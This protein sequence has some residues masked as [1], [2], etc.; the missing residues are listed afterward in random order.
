MIP[1]LV[2]LA[3]TDVVVITTFGAVNGDKVGSTTTLGFQSCKQC[4]GTCASSVTKGQIILV[5][6]AGIIELIP[7]PEVKSLLLNEDWVPVN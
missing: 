7:Y 3:A 2:A 5:A 4:D 1:N 6:I